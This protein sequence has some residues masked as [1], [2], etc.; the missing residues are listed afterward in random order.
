MTVADRAK[1]LRDAARRA[2]VNLRARWETPPSG[3]SDL[4]ARVARLERDGE[5][6]GYLGP[7]W[8]SPCTE[9]RKAVEAGVAPNCIG[10][11]TQ[12]GCGR[13]RRAAP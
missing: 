12:T 9:T 6:C 11:T 2:W 3:P 7:G 8:G 13:W 10:T 1:K 4:E 5:L